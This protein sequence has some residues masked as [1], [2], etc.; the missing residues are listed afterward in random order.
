MDL[1]LVE[2]HN[3]D[4]A[5]RPGSSARLGTKIHIIIRPQRQRDRREGAAE[6]A[7]QL[8][9]SLKSYLMARYGQTE[10]GESFEWESS[11]RQLA[12]LDRA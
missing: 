12:C 3:L 2:H 1:T 6:S 5:S 8:L 11:R 4:R 9:A 7:R 10:G